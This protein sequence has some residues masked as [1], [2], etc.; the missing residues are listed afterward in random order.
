M[1][2]IDAQILFVYTD[3]N[4]FDAVT[5]DGISNIKDI[6]YINSGLTRSGHTYDP[7]I[8]DV[9]KVMVNDDG[10]AELVNFYSA[11]RKDENDRVTFRTGEPLFG[12]ADR[13]PG[14]QRWYGPD[15]A[16]LS[17]DR[18]KRARVAGGPL[19]QSVYFGLEGLIRTICQNYEAIGSGFR[20]LSVNTDGKITTRLCFSSTDQ[21]VA[22]GINNNENAVSESFEYQI[23]IDAD[24]ITLF[25]GNID[26]K[27]GKRVNNFTATITPQG[28]IIGTCGEFMQFALYAT[29]ALTQKIFDSNKK[30]LYNKSVAK[31]SDGVLVKEVMTGNYIREIDGDFYENVT[32]TKRSM[33]NKNIQVSNFNDVSSEVNRKSAGLNI[34]D[35]QTQPLV[36]PIQK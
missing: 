10:S 27:T 32:G 6:K 24:G 35:L 22:K 34:T 3:R 11:Y 1:R 30:L 31:S 7:E 15:G 26:G 4:C 18:G 17:L 29:G 28:D 25:V 12:G 8:G 21:L 16:N 20:V 5:L 2:S 33:N 23:D 14:D 19:A 36:N 13:L 9:V